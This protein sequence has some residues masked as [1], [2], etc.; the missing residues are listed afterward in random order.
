MSLWSRTFSNT[1]SNVGSGLVSLFTSGVRAV[2]VTAD[3]DRVD[4]R[5][6][7][8]VGTCDGALPGGISWAV[9]LRLIGGGVVPTD[10][11]DGVRNLVFLESDLLE[12]LFVCWLLTNASK[13]P[14]ILWLGALLMLLAECLLKSK[15]L[16]VAVTSRAVDDAVDVTEKV[17]VV[18]RLFASI[19]KKP[20]LLLVRLV[21]RL[22]SRAILSFNKGSAPCSASPPF[23][24]CNVLMQAGNS[25]R[26]KSTVCMC[27]ISM[28]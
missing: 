14:F 23:R 22:E 15:L 19:V 11:V 1:T 28:M 9:S 7:T 17:F 18:I 20:A 6:L 3:V 25:S 8:R 27:L 5:L 16:G 13:L 10:V 26:R 12:A 21:V 24:F 2:L 4:R